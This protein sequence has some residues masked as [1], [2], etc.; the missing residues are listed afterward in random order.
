MKPTWKL[1]GLAVACSACC[2]LPI[3]GTLLAGLGLGGIGTAVAGWGAGLAALTVGLAVTFPWKHLSCSSPAQA[4][5]D[6]G[7]S[8]TIRATGSNSAACI[9]RNWR[10]AL[11]IPHDRA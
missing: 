4:S 3:A 10:T 11:S 9:Q 8:R 6:Y 1:L 7:C 2:A 5:D